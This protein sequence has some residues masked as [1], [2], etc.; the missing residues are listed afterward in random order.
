MTTLTSQLFFFFLRKIFLIVWR[1]T[2]NVQTKF[3]D[4]RGQ[5]KTNIS[6]NCPIYRTSPKHINFICG[7]QGVAWSFHR[8]NKEGVLWRPQSTLFFSNSTLSAWPFRSEQSIV[9]DSSKDFTTP[10]CDVFFLYKVVL[11]FESMIKPWV[12]SLTTSSFLKACEQ[13]FPV[14]QFI[15]LPVKCDH[16]HESLAE[17]HLKVLWPLY[18][19]ILPR[20]NSRNSINWS[21]YF[22]TLLKCFLFYNRWW[23]TLRNRYRCVRFRTQCPGTVYQESPPIWYR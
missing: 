17:R 13:G 22:G 21:L 14:V 6:F 12:I 1:L 18:F 3:G 19:Q 9:H 15:V 7:W 4:S 2:M 10:A 5:I 20:G 16:S 8:R 23:K 11:T